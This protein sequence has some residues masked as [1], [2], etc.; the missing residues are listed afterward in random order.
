MI[1]VMSFSPANGLRD[2]VTY[3]RVPADED[4]AREQVQGRLDEIKNY[5]NDTLLPGVATS[6]DL[7]AHKAENLIHTAGGTANAITIAT[8]GDFDYIQGNPLRFK[9]TADSAAGAVTINVDGKGVKSGKKPDGSN[10]TIKNNKVY[11]WYFDVAGDCFFLVASAEGDAVAGDVLAGKKFSNDDDTGIVGTM[12]SKVGSA[13][14]ITPSGSDQAIPQGYY[15]GLI[16]SGKVSGRSVTAGDVAILSNNAEVDTAQASVF[17][18]IKE[19]RIH[20]SG[21]IRVK[22]DLRST[23]SSANLVRAKIYVNGIAVGT[24]RSTTSTGAT[25][26]TEDITV[27]AEDLIQ[28]YKKDY[29]GSVRALVSNFNLFSNSSMYGDILS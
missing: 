15:D 3:P 18:K 28:I 4:A 24:E 27:N 14:V 6:E 20:A 12:P 2:K 22:F 9:A 23:T 16:T 11:S 25:T 5:I 7:D 8:G 13:T 10:P 21:T 17:T 29:S 1:D 26:Y 19:I